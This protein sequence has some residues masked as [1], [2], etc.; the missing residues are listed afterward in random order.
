MEWLGKNVFVLICDSCS[1]IEWYAKNLRKSQ[2]TDRS[3][4]NTVYLFNTRAIPGSDLA[5]QGT[6]RGRRFQLLI[7]R[8]TPRGLRRE[9][10]ELTGSSR[11]SRSTASWNAGIS[12]GGKGGDPRH[13][14][15]DNPHGVDE[16]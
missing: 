15:A 3:N 11:N 9:R 4:T 7:L 2:R 12:R 1:H 5:A 13:L 16:G 14:P 8:F 10:L 6:P